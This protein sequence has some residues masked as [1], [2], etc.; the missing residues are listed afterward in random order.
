MKNL[1][2]LDN[3]GKT[4]DRYTVVIGWD[5]FTMSQNPLSPQGVNQYMGTF[6]SLTFRKEDKE[7]KWEDVPDDVKAAIQ[8]RMKTD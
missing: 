7:I 1:K 2:V 3:G 8:E 6:L 5:V 4:F